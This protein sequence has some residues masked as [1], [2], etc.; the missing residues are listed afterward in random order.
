MLGHTEARPKEPGAGNLSST[1]EVYIINASPTTQERRLG[2]SRSM[3]G[4]NGDTAFLPVMKISSLTA[5]LM[6]TNTCMFAL[7]T[8]LVL[9][10]SVTSNSFAHF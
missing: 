10:T 3:E 9:I 6:H 8:I 2:V 4:E 1:M 5:K 7:S